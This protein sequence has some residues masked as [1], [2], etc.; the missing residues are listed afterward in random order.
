[1]KSGRI[2]GTRSST[3]W[4][5]EIACGND[6]VEALLAAVDELRQVGRGE[7]WRIGVAHDNGCPALDGA[8][9]P[10]CTCELIQLEARR[11]A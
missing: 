1:V 4:R 5:R 9:M 11:A 6:P 10:A 7:V 3:S 8:G 2:P